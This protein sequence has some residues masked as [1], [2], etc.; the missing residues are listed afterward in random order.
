[1]ESLSEKVFDFLVKIPKRY[2]L[3]TFCVMAGVICLIIGL[4]QLSGASP[5]KPQNIGQMNNQPAIASATSFPSLKIDVEGAVINPGVYSVASNARVQDALVAA[6][7]LSSSADREIVAKTINLA[8]RLT[9]GMKIY[10]PKIGDPSVTAIGGIQG[11]SDTSVLGSQTGLV[12]IN[13]ASSQELDALPGVGPATVQK[14]I[15]A[16]PFSN[17]DDLIAKKAVSQSVFTKIKDLIT[18][19]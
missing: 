1:M 19:N 18:V 4:M 5:Q 12:N 14:I 15:V 2:Y 13:T 17:T 9:D 3:F 7:G 11:S 6:G 8:A 10:M 16:R